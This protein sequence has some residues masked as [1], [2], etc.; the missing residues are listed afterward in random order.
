MTGMQ[1]GIDGLVVNKLRKFV[2][3]RGWLAELFRENEFPEEFH[4]AMIYVSMTGPGEARG[5]HEHRFQTDY[6]CILGPSNF[7]IYF[8]DNRPQSPTFKKKLQI[9]TGFNDI[10]SILVP[11][12]VVHGYKNVGEKEGYIL[13]APDRLYCGK[14]KKGSPDEIRYENDPGGGFR[15]D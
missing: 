4:P 5:P 10:V 3:H 6:F 14:G 12:G 7:R 8:W 13:N 1:T 2:D 11:P 9:E 15:L